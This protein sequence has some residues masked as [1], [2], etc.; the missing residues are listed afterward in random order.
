MG[1][2]ER[3]VGSGRFVWIG[4]LGSLGVALAGCGATGSSSAATATPSSAGSSTVA[5]TAPGAS[6]GS[7]STSS[8]GTTAITPPTTVAASSVTLGWVAPT[9]NS[10]GTPI[11]D[12]AG[13][14]IHYGTASSDYSQTVSISNAGLTRYVVDNLPTGT[15]YFAITAYNAHGIES[16]LSGEV[17]T[18]V[19]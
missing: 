16:A 4:L 7:G 19:N 10:N 12:L 1:K 3:G 13:Y 15:Y 11:T 9:E 17:T 8:G 14:K 5:G 18:T 6:T 2:A